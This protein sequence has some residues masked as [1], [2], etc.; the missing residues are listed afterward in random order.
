M[1]RR[2][3]GTTDYYPKEL[4]ERESVFSIWAR[5]AGNFGFGRVDCPA[6]EELSL[7]TKKSGPEIVSQIFTLDRRGGEQLGL[8][9][10]FTASLARMFIA[11]QKE[12]K[13]PLKWFTIGP[14]W[15]Y[16][17]PQAGRQRE[18]YQYNAEVYGASGPVCDAEVIRLACASIE[19]LGISRKN[20]V[21]RVNSRQLLEG[22]VGAFVPRAEVSGVIRL[23]D[24]RRKM[25]P[26]AFQQALSQHA[27]KGAGELL[28]FLN[29]R[30]DEIGKKKLN[31]L[32]R[33]GY[34]DMVW[35][36]AL[37]E[38]SNI[39]FDLSVARGLD[40]YTGMVFEI[41][42]AGGKYRALGGGGRYDQLIGLF[43][44]EETPAA[45][46]AVGYSTVSLFMR[47]L[48]ILPGAGPSPQYFVLILK[49]CMQDAQ[50]FISRLRR[51]YSVEYDLNERSFANQMKYAKA[52]G[53]KNLIV[54]GPDD[55]NSETVRVKDLETGSESVVARK[56]IV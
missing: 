46:F 10:E 34:E 51:R 9:F 49:G 30:L 15:R 7:L 52:I 25:S 24:R 42:D 19:N 38:G 45:G 43:G 26:S 14:V 5:T 21:V 1:S 37:L 13:K 35:L 50:N 27:G 31:P 22:I 40:Y 20:Y 8:R 48:K 41:Y 16:E 17:Q 6:F 28:G 39:V 36:F 2:V 29:C 47:D 54:F 4:L 18:F 23:I 11:R 56:E 33:K 32:A 3:K 44:G 53:A 12:L 55:V